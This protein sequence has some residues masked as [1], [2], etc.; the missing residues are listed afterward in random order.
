[1][2]ILFRVI[3]KLKCLIFRLIYSKFFGRFGARVSILSPSGIEGIGNIY[4][5]DDIYVANGSLLAATTITGNNNAELIIHSG[6]SLGKNNHIYATNSIIIGRDVLTANNVYISDNTHEFTNTD[7]AIKH[8]PVKT[9]KK[10]TI[11]EGAWLG[12]NVC[13]LG[14]SVGKGSVV[15]ANSV[16]TNDLP[17]YCVAVGSPARVVKK[18][19]SNLC[20]WEKVN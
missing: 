10:V 6:C 14:A 16:V 20:V 11:G 13:V 5:F 15:G 12:Q 9:L 19:N 17:D 18:Y 1:M 8:Q 7:K 4:L 2:F 3:N